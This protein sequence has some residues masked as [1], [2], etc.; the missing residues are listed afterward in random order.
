MDWQTSKPSQGNVGNHYC[1]QNLLVYSSTGPGSAS[2]PI[3][4]ELTRNQHVKDQR[5]KPTVT[6]MFKDPPEGLIGE[7]WRILLGATKDKLL[8]PEHAWQYRKKHV[9][10]WEGEEPVSDSDSGALAA[11]ST[12][13]EPPVG[14][15]I[16]LDAC[17]PGFPAAASELEPPPTPTDEVAQ[18]RYLEATLEAMA[19]ETA[20]RRA[21]K[22]AEIRSLEDRR[23]ALVAEKAYWRSQVQEAQ[24]GAA[25]SEDERQG[26][27]ADVEPSGAGPVAELGRPAASP[28]PGSAAPAPGIA[29]APATSGQPSSSARPSAAPPP[30]GP[31]AP[32]PGTASAPDFE[33]YIAQVCREYPDIYERA[34]ANALNSGSAASPLPASRDGA[35]ASLMPITA[36]ASSENATPSLPHSGTASGSVVP[37]AGPAEAVDWQAVLGDGRRLRNK[38]R[39]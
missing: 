32:A 11:G 26:A 38:I 2:S 20:Q 14:E 13:P 3:E 29:S 7:A 4:F 28:P 36:A 39:K 8:L 9:L 27:D 25:S 18:L 23:D 10:K 30:P 1:Q 31:A 12:N 16:S 15:P 24:R 17:A 6:A 21:A 35:D 5:V 33:Q 19:A 22:D 34:K 37:A